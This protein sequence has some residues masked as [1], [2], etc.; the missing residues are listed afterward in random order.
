MSW[1]AVLAL[2]A[3][4]YALKAVGAVAASRAPDAALSERLEVLVV[5]VIAGLIAVQV[6]GDGEHLVVDGRA[7][8]LL[9][10]AVLVWRKVPLLLVALAAG[11][12]AAALHAL[13]W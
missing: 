12:T 7:P 10:A 11:G 1:T 9:V 6:F 13:G 2:C 8:A 5:P 3:A 4:A